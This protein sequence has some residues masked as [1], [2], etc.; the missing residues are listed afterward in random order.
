VQRIFVGDVQG[1]ADELGEILERARADFG[2]EFELWLV[3]D[4]IN[5]GPDNLR[6]LQQVRELRDA[7]RA[8]VVLGNHETGLFMK[9]LGLRKLRKSDTIGD[10]LESPNAGEWFAWLRSLP[11]AESATLGEQPF[12]MV[13]A[14]AHP[15]W[16]LDQLLTLSARAHESLS[17][18][19]F[20]ALAEFFSPDNRTDPWRDVVD[21]LTRCRSIDDEGF[22]SDELPTT[23]AHA[24]HARF[25]QG[26]HDYGVVYGHWALQGLH[27]APGFRGLD[28]GCVHHG[29]DRDGFLTAWLPDATQE[30]PFDLTDAPEERFWQIPARRAYYTS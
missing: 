9:S 24:W 1:C 17:D 26:E 10:I 15:E 7:G 8:R 3:G 30:R 28:T 23:P 5:R 2:S 27:I 6:V 22:W 4:M 11:L 25:A 13:H 19:P 21:R 12:A 29:R 18:G 16:S 14:S 20:E